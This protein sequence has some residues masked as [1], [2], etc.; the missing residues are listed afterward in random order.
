MEVTQTD[1]LP[2]FVDILLWVLVATTLE[3]GKSGKVLDVSHKSLSLTVVFFVVAL[4]GICSSVEL[5]VKL[6]IPSYEG[7]LLGGLLFETGKEVID[8]VA[9][10]NAWED[11]DCV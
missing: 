10:L 4:G 5:K 8:R 11:A 6:S 7:I 1:Q 9:E 3:R 2:E